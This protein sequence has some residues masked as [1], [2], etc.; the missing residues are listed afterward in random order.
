[1]RIGVLSNA[2]QKVVSFSG[3]FSGTFGGDSSG[4]SSGNF[5]GHSTRPR[6]R[7]GRL[8]EESKAIERH[9]SGVD[10]LE[11]IQKRFTEKSV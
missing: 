4:N 7:L 6:S 2:G 11:T 3:N 9:C 1:M 10:T 5:S 8:L